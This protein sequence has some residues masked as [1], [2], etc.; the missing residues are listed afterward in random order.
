MRRATGR[1]VEMTGPEEWFP[2]QSRACFSLVFLLR[3]SS[4]LLSVASTLCLCAFLPRGVATAVARRAVA[5][6]F[7]S[8]R[9]QVVPFSSSLDDTTLCNSNLFRSSATAVFPQPSFFASSYTDVFSNLLIWSPHTEKV[10]L[11]LATDQITGSISALREVAWGAVA[12]CQRHK[13]IE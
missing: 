13:A 5:A 8:S 9:V 7:E 2:R 4:F 6:F 11:L 12:V 3:S 1:A 10:D